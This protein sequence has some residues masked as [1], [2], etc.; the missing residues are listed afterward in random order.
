MASDVATFLRN[1]YLNTLKEIVSS[2]SKTRNRILRKFVDIAKIVKDDEEGS[3]TPTFAFISA[4]Y[5]L[6]DALAEWRISTE[7]SNRV[8]R[9]FRRFTPINILNDRLNR[10]KKFLEERNAN[11]ALLVSLPSRDDL[12]GSTC[13]QEHEEDDD[14]S[15][16]NNILGFEEHVRNMVD[17]LSHSNSEGLMSNYKMMG[18]HGMGGSGKTTLVKKV[19]QHKNIKSRH[20]ILWVCLWDITDEHE[21]DCVGLCPR[22]RHRTLPFILEPNHHSRTYLQLQVLSRNRLCQHQILLGH[23]RTVLA[24]TPS[25]SPTRYRLDRQRQKYPGNIIASLNLN[26]NKQVEGIDVF[27]SSIVSTRD[28]PNALWSVIN[29]L[30]MNNGDVTTASLSPSQDV[31]S[32]YVDLYN[33]NNRVIF[34]HVAFQLHDVNRRNPVNDSQLLLNDV[35]TLSNAR[36]FNNSRTR[37]LVGITNVTQDWSMTPNPVAVKAANDAL[38]Q[39]FVQG[40]SY[41]AIANVP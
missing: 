12:D 31:R 17:W 40:T 14:P 19:L 37:L 34:D 33:Y 16:N 27:Y 21:I 15:C 36:Q 25:P 30:M 7:Q 6:N 5:D 23:R 22:R 28:F 32:H 29:D 26:N 18:I 10:L 11:P 41:W 4:L 38:T 8:K 35:R 2:E 9:I 3:L 1:Q 13:F 39:R 20:K 24:H